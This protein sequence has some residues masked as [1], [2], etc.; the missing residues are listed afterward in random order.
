MSRV[1]TESSIHLGV[2][3]AAL[4]A[5]GYAFGVQ[6]PHSAPVADA[7]NVEPL[8]L[9]PSGSAFLLTADVPALQRSEVG[10]LLAQ[11]VGR[12]TGKLAT[13]CGFDPLRRL[14]QLAIAVP[15]AGNANQP[16]HPED[17]AIVASG[18]FTAEEIVR[19][20]SASIRERGGDPVTSELG[21]F[22][23]VRDRAH[24]RGTGEVAVKD[25]GPLIVS[26]GSYFR[27]LLDAAEGRAVRSEPAASDARHAEL[28]RTL[29]AA[30]LLATWL[31]GDGWLERVVG[32]GGDARLSPLSGMR[33]VAARVDGGHEARLEVLLD[34]ADSDSAARISSLLGELR[35]SLGAL[36]LDP[37]LSS[38]AQRIRVA[39]VGARLT[40]TLTA[41]PSELTPLLDLLLGPA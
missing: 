11:R 10:A 7:T 4:V 24:E 30:P 1:S 13:L 19:C 36:P 14:N 23:S 2:V 38:A 3:I 28:R 8:A 20:A 9:I 25:G 26:G 32:E 16:E 18:Q 40:L 37:A 39:Q 29:G 17:F 22:S 6:A 5:V 34:C 15:S 31:L 41:S 12:A 33:S 35:G 21:H 27:E